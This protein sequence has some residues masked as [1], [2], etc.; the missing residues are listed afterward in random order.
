[1]FAVDSW[2]QMKAESAMNI[3]LKNFF[4]DD[5]SLSIKGWKLLFPTLK[6]HSANGNDVVELKLYLGKYSTKAFSSFRK[7]REKRPRPCSAWCGIKVEI[8]GL[9]RTSPTLWIMTRDSRNSTISIGISKSTL[10]ACTMATAAKGVEL[11]AWLLFIRWLGRPRYGRK[12][13]CQAA[14][15]TENSIPFNC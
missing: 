11:V 14:S 10:N 1:M 5:S 7:R 15:V 12:F 8:A 2:Q 6:C 9:K 4:D 3:K 13:S